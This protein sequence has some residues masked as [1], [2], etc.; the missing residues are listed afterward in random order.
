[1]SKKPGRAF[2][3]LLIALVLGAAPAFSSP[4]ELGATLDDFREVEAPSQ[5][6]RVYSPFA[7]RS[8]PNQ[9]LFGDMH[10]HTDLS[11]DAGLIGTRLD[12]G[13]RLPLRQG[14]EGDVQYRSAGAAGPDYLV[15]T[16]L[17]SSRDHRS[18]A[19]SWGWHP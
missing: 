7:G 19:N 11:F 3:A 6:Q 9:V 13:R 8:Y 18:F 14:R 12:G 10:F 2:S 15:I 5:E 1:M 16:A 17:D 4:Q